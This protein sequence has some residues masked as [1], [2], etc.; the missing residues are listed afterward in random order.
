MQPFCLGP[1]RARW[2]DRMFQADFLHPNAMPICLEQTLF[3]LMQAQP[4]K[5][6]H[7]SEI[8]PTGLGPGPFLFIVQDNCLPSW[9][10]FVS[11]FNLLASVKHPPLI[12]CFQDPPVWR[13]HLPLYT[14]FTLFAPIA[15]RCPQLAFYAFRSLIDMATIITIFTHRSDRATLE[16]S[17]P[18][19]FSAKAETFHIVNCYSV[20]GSTATERTISATL[21]L[22][23]LA[24]PTQVVG[25]FHIH[26]P[27][28]DLIR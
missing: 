18:S 20:W 10:V 14:G 6:S 2:A 23:N 27:S 13:N 25:D 8:L 7:S 17:A 1:L 11:L 26:H 12:V 19:L 3:L 21:A 4:G 9:D 16:I 28:A 15:N 24:F 22:L 5:M